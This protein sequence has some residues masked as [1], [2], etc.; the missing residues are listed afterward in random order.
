MSTNINEYIELILQIAKESVAN[1]V[2]INEDKIMQAKEGFDEATFNNFKN[3]VMGF[4]DNATQGKRSVAK[5]K[6][7]NMNKELQPLALKY[8]EFYIILWNSMLKYKDLDFDDEEREKLKKGL[9][10]GRKMHTEFYQ[11]LK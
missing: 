8:L 10:E 4:V 7:D 2:E 3:D 5:T 11:S 1:G 6:W 9:E